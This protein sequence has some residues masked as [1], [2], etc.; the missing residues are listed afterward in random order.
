[1]NQRD[2]Y[3]KR[4]CRVFFL[5]QTDEETKPKGKMDFLMRIFP[6]L[7][8]NKYLKPAQNKYGE[9]RENTHW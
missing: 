6:K 4:L 9:V 5:P 3:I 1:M 2:G 7:K 8:Q